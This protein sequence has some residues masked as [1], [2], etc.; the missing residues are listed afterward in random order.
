M[1]N[2][3]FYIL[4]GVIFLISNIGSIIIAQYRSNKKLAKGIQ[5]LL[6]ME[7]EARY[8]KCANKGFSTLKE[9]AD[10]ES[11]YIVY[12]SLGKNGVMDLTHKQ[13]MELP[14]RK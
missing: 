3:A 5:I 9:K 7:L 11:I 6:R 4:Y 1:N 8:K 13:M 12:H 10:F 2:I 14:N